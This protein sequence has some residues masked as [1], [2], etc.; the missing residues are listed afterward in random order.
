MLA[1][2][3]LIDLA[4]DPSLDATTRLVDLPGATRNY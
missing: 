2:P 1:V 4:Y 3:G